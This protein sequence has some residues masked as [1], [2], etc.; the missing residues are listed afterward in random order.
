IPQRGA[1]CARWFP[2]LGDQGCTASSS[3]LA[4]PGGSVAS[5]GDAERDSTGRRHPEPGDAL[6]DTP[7]RVSTLAE[8]VGAGAGAALVEARNRITFATSSSS[9]AS[10]VEGPRDVLVHP[11]AAAWRAYRRY[12]PAS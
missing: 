1:L 12:V 5:P 7:R 3:I 9:S 4:M 6:R 2:F 11:S 10:P 8:E